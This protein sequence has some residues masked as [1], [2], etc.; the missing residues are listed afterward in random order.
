MIRNGYKYTEKDFI[1]RVKTNNPKFLEENKIM[2]KYTSIF[3]Y[4]FVQT[5]Y[6]IVRMQAAMIARGSQPTIN[7]SICYSEYW[8]NKV[9]ERNNRMY[10][11]LSIDKYNGN[12][13]AQCRKCGSHVSG[14]MK[15]H[16]TGGVGCKN[17]PKIKT[18]NTL[19]T[20]QFIDRCVSIFGIDRYDYSKSEYVTSEHKVK[21]VCK[22]H[23]QEFEQ[24]PH[25]HYSGHEGCPKCN[26]VVK[27]ILKGIRNQ[28]E[29]EQI[30][31]LL[32]VLRLRRDEENFYKVGISSNFKYRLYSYKKCPYTIEVMNVIRGDMFEICNLEIEFLN[33]F[34]M[35]KYKPLIPFAGKTECLTVNPIDYWYDWQYEQL[36]INNEQESYY[37]IL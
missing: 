32:Y 14:K 4:L 30:K 22:K 23:A 9:Q 35:F 34:K 21:I 7:A 25:D 3:K 36:N 27:S 2:S 29:L 17:C 5:K 12:F 8:K 13:I 33:T 28:K 24:L 19:T 11:Y 31:G 10:N 16:M 18:K 20:Q 15:H 26:V 1:E 6:G 37:E